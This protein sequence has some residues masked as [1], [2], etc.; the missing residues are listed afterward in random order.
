MSSSRQ[1]LTGTS[2]SKHERVSSTSTSSSSRTANTSGIATMSKSALMRSAGFV[3]P[4]CKSSLL[5]GS[6]QHDEEETET[7]SKPNH[8]WLEQHTLTGIS[9]SNITTL[10][11][12]LTKSVFPKMKFADRDTQMVFSNEKN[13]VCQFVITHRNLHTNIS[14]IEWWKHTQKYVRQGPCGG[15]HFVTICLALNSTFRLNC[16]QEFNF[17]AAGRRK[18]LSSSAL[19]DAHG[20]KRG[21]FGR[22]FSK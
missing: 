9:R 21:P 1:W 13:S 10:N 15:A 18:F 12:V 20:E 2:I 11:L 5:E 16:Q 19:L 6:E 8:V 22:T 4:N 14:P 3:S 17:W 7:G